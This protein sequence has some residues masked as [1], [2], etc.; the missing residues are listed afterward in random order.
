[1]KGRKGIVAIVALVVVFCFAMPIY[2]G[3]E[4]PN[5]TMEIVEPVD[6]NILNQVEQP[7]DVNI[8][9]EDPIQ[10]EIVNGDSSALEPYQARLSKILNSGNYFG[11]ASFTV[12]PNKRLIVDNF[13]ALLEVPTGGEGHLEVRTTV[14][15]TVA[16]HYFPLP[17]AFSGPTPGVDTLILAKQVRLV[18]DPGTTFEVTWYR[19]TTGVIASATSSLTGVLE[20]VAP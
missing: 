6:V 13:T 20:P 19:T 8:A 11:V 10:M 18:A 17:F 5:Q 7:V 14:A 15:S 4:K 1:M 2:A 12:P 16:I 3:D 9:N